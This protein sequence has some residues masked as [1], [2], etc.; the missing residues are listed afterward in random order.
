MSTLNLDTDTSFTPAHLTL[1]L[2]CGK[3]TIVL[4]VLPSQS[5][6]EVK[7]S[8]LSI[9]ESLNT[10]NFP[11]TTTP[12][13]SDPEDL[14]LGITK[15]RRTG[16]DASKGWINVEDASSFVAAS[17][18]K[19]GKRKTTPAASGPIE[20]IGDLELKDGSYIAYRLRR[21]VD[22]LMDEDVEEE[23]AWNVVVPS[24]D[25]EEMEVDGAVPPA[26]GRME[27]EDDEED[28]PVPVPRNNVAR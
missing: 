26:D 10:T 15:E 4:S 19:A 28:I 2:K 20:T 6:T 1:F 17:N 12:L 14:E 7:S 24:Y 27:D 11:G 23:P 22:D 9:L 3:S 21:T 25:D 16:R 18:A 8:L 13:P 5:L